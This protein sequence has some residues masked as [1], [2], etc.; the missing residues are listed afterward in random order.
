VTLPSCWSTTTE[1]VALNSCDVCSQRYA[2]TDSVAPTWNRFYP[3]ARPMLVFDPNLHDAVIFDC[4]G[5][6]VDTMPLHHTAWQTAFKRFGA[7]FEFTW[8]LFNRRAGMTLERTV[9]ELNREF[10]CNLAP[11]DVAA[12]QRE[13]YLRCTDQIEPI[14]YV[15]AFA[16]S[17]AQKCSL[18]VASG[19]SRSSVEDALGRIGLLDRIATIVTGSDVAEGKPAPDIFLLAA[20]RLSVPPCRCLVV[21]DGE[22]GLQ[23]ARRAGMD[24]YRVDR[25]GSVTWLPRTTSG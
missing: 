3:L 23:A 11:E 12:A 25:D 2:I 8:E 16:R 20:S 4:D 19:S 14:E 13:A 15:V 5:T 10:R 18:A 9:E 17:V 1:S 22:L 7:P 24:A 6:L 21:E